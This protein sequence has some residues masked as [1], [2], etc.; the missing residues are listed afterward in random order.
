VNMRLKLDSEA[1]S[2]MSVFSSVT[3]VTPLDTFEVGNKRA[4]VVEEGMA[5]L[6][7]GKN[8]ATVKLLE[9]M[10]HKEIVIF[11]KSD[12]PI[13]T[14]ASIFRPIKILTGYQSTDSLGNKKVVIELTKKVKRSTIELAQ[15]VLKRYFNISELQIR[16][17]KK[18]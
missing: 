17:G 12:D 10:M 3:N 1:I 9:K 5:P 15:Q 14:L 7:V 4:F 2:A 13:K 11:E 6:C 18:A 8:G 16:Y